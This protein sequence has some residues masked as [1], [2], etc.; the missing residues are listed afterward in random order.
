MNWIAEVELSGTVFM[1]LYWVFVTWCI[2]RWLSGARRIRFGVR[3]WLGSVGLVLGT[4]SAMLFAAFFVYFWIEG[5]L[6]AH[7][8][9]LWIYYYAGELIAVLGLVV[10]FGGRGWIRDSSAIISIVMLFQWWRLMSSSIAL[11]AKLTLIMFSVLALSTA[12]IFGK[13]YLFCQTDHN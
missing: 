6:I 5:D 10:G 13:R 8:A 9:M 1:L 11:A 12:I 3:D 2:I 7:G 4:C